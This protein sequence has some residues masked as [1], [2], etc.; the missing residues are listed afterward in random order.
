[1]MPGGLSTPMSIPH[2]QQKTSDIL[3]LAPQ[4]FYQERGTPIAVR[5]LAEELADAGYAVD[6][7]CFHEGEPYAYPG[8]NLYRIPALPGIRGVKPGFS[9]K[10]ILCDALMLVQGLRLVRQK[11]YRILHA[12]EESVFIAWLLR[13]F[14]RTP[15]IYDM[16]SLLSRQ[17]T[18]KFPWL[19]RGGGL[20]QHLEK[21]AMQASQGVLAVCEDLKRQVQEDAPATPVQVLE[22]ISLLDGEGAEE[23]V[24]DIRRH[25]RIRGCMLMYVGNLEQYQG[26]D[27]LLEAFALFPRDERQE[28]GLVLIGGREEDIARYRRK[29]ES[30]GIGGQ[31]HFP[32]PRPVKHLGGYLR[33][34][35]ILL[36]PRIQGNNTPMKLYSYLA[37]GKALI[38]TRLPTHT[39]VLDDDIALLC[40]PEPEA[41]MQAMHTLARDEELRKRL[42]R[43]AGLR[44]RERYSR[45]AYRE[46]LR[47]FYLE[48]VGPPV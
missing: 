44:A 1:M 22:D 17:L 28:Y 27:L 4:P 47:R 8:V 32:G 20:L 16:D 12:V 39:Q 15:Y 25:Y 5:L 30:L 14:F 18:D 7:L 9:L 38:A 3:I 33:Q 45:E 37:S 19:A 11:R 42:G 34:A 36:S 26:I 24:D 40:E 31:A 2:E 41:C 6:L 43:A 46:K 29:A 13:V 10:K 23:A 35:D 21:G 48:V